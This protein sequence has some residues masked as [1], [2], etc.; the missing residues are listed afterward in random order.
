MSS[1]HITTKRGWFDVKDAKVYQVSP[2]E[3]KV[4]SKN[5]RVI[6]LITYNGETKTLAQWADA[7][8]LPY[9]RLQDRLDRMV[10][11]MTAEDIFSLR[12]LRYI[13]R[14]LKKKKAESHADSLPIRDTGQ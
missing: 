5:G 2:F 10:E 9:T 4:V 12:D 14:D 3:K 13:K 8:G 11:G 6:R 7:T 1:G